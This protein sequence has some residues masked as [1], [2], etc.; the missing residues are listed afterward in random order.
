MKI[1]KFESVN[2]D[3]D[4]NKCSN[5]ILDVFGDNLNISNIK[6]LG[7]FEYN[8]QCSV[9]SINRESFNAF[10]ILFNIIDKNSSDFIFSNNECF[11]KINNIED[12]C[13]EIKIVKL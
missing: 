10:K 1:K 4:Y 8:F 11:A 9:V 6:F 5:L 3:F 2:N 12:F 7:D 13:N